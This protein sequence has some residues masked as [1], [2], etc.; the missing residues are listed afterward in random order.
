MNTSDVLSPEGARFRVGWAKSSRPTGNRPPR[1]HARIARTT[2][3][4][5]IGEPI[6][7]GREDLA[8]PTKML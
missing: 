1:N 8:H 2:E 3:P 5:G 4:S 7:V 6:A